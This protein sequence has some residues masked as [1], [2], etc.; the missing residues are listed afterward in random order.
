MNP[1]WRKTPWSD[2]LALHR[3]SVVASVY[4]QGDT[5]RSTVTP[6]K[7]RN[8]QEAMRETERAVGAA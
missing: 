4:K 8:R 5:W 1:D 7:H 2:V 6:T 3:G